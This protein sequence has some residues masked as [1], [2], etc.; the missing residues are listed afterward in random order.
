[1]SWLNKVL[2][3]GNDTHT[4]LGIESMSFSEAVEKIDEWFVE[5]FYQLNK[6]ELKYVFST[7]VT[8][9]GGRP[10]LDYRNIGRDDVLLSKIF[11]EQK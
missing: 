5:H 1:M 4:S 3:L 8:H 9:D 10:L 2:H 11:G 6:K 7:I